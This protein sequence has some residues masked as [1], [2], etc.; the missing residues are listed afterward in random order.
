M[1]DEALKEIKNSWWS[2]LVRAKSIFL[3][4]SLVG[5]LATNIATLV[6][7]STHD[8]FH[9][10]V[11]R[12]LAI[13]GDAFADRA[14]RQSPQSQIEAKVKARTVELHTQN[15]ELS[16]KNQKLVQQLDVN[17]KTAKA[18]ASKV[19]QRLEKGVARNTAAL[20]AESVP[21]LGV[22]V[23][24][25]VTTLD[26]YDACAT[27][28]DMN[29]LLKMMG[30]GEEKDDLCGRRLPTKDQLISTIKTDWQKSLE[31]VSNEAK[32]ANVLMPEVRLPT[33]IELNKVICPFVA[34]ESMCQKS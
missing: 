32:K 18:T 16:E 25:A 21:Y 26:L 8:F 30:Q 20:P 6:S 10:A 28:S 12:V 14:M 24:L 22:G 17:A 15:V 4:I 1:A 13:G 3:A 27:M 2:R 19:Y 5:L 29:S 11:W 23:T 7:A 34:S 33:L 31:A 9:S